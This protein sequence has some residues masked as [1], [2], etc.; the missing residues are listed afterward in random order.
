MGGS[1]ISPM[2]KQRL[3]GQFNDFMADGF[4]TALAAQGGTVIVYASD[5][6][7]ELSVTV[8]FDD[9]N[10]VRWTR[11]DNSEPVQVHA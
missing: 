6:Q 1:A 11:V 7:A 4:E 2:A 5:P 3:Q 9:E 10:S 8:T